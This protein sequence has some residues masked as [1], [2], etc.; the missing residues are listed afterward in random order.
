[1]KVN[2]YDPDNVEKGR[3][4]LLNLAEDL[5]EYCKIKVSPA[6]ER[7]GKGGKGAAG[8][9]KPESAEEIREKAEAQA[10]FVKLAGDV[11]GD[12]EVDFDE[13]E[14]RPSYI[15]MELESTTSFN[16]IDID[17]M[18]EHTTLDDFMR[19]LYLDKSDTFAKAKQPTNVLGAVMTGEG[20][21]ELDEEL[22]GRKGLVFEDREA[23]D[24]QSDDMLRQKALQNLRE[25]RM[26]IK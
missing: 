23:D 6:A 12:E 19:G 20:L 5:K 10:G 21:D 17:A 15:F 1:M 4:I 18:L 7:K 9:R 25:R 16:D 2:V 11:E 26:R 3:M 24:R 8:E 22:D 13:V 14:D